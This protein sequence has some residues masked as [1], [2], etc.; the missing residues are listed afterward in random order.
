[1]SKRRSKWDQPTGGGND[2]QAQNEPIT[3]TSAPMSSVAV[4]S[5][6]AGAG[7]VPNPA[8]AAAAVVS[9]VQANPAAAVSV[10]ALAAAARIN[11]LLASQG[12]LAQNTRPVIRPMMTDGAA[13]GPTMGTAGLGGAP[14]TGANAVGLNPAGAARTLADAGATDIEPASPCRYNAEVEINDYPNRAVLTKTVILLDIKRQTGAFVSPRGRYMTK[15]EKGQA[16]ND[17]KPQYLFIQSDEQSKVDAAVARIN[18]LLGIKTTPK[19]A[20]TSGASSSS[21]SSSDKNNYSQIYTKGH[22]VQEKL[23]IG[24]EL[25]P[26]GFNVIERIQGPDGQ[27]LKHIQNESGAKVVLRGRGSGFMEP[28]SGRESFEAIHLYINHSTKDGLANAKKLCQNLID[29]IR[30]EAATFAP[31]YAPA[32]FGSGY[33]YQ[34]LPGPQQMPQRP[35]APRGSYSNIPP[36]GT[37]PPHQASAGPGSNSSYG[38]QPPYHQQQQPPHQPYGGQPPP[39][40]PPPPAGGGPPPYQQQ[41]YGH[42]AN[43]PAHQQQ[44]MPPPGQGPPPP[45]QG[46]PLPPP[47]GQ[48]PPPPPPTGPGEDRQDSSGQAD[49]ASSQQGQASSSQH[50]PQQQQ[51]QQQ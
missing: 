38:Q 21:S 10:V 39:Y 24:L 2:G 43:Q 11:A 15:E 50:A 35:T 4:T 14:L 41:P 31:A 16:A 17:E 23:F 26:E 5:A 42:Y 29:T 47:P 36:P 25:A 27:Y 45:G 22:Y 28:T 48:G 20:A 3:S 1:M 19:P 6:N 18:N 32:G 8:A 34:P 49:G 40:G 30:Q 33:G 44:Y 12:K 46:P 51:Q 7:L 9:A 37:A 13:T